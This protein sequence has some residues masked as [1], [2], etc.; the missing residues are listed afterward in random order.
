MEQS[1]AGSARSQGRPAGA[2]G[3]RAAVLLAVAALAAGGL[4]AAAEAATFTVNSTLDAVDRNPGDGLC[5]TNANTCTL[6]AAIQEANART[7]A[8]AIVVPTGVYAITRGGTSATTG[9]FDVTAPLTITGAGAGLTILDGGTP[10][11]GSIPERRGLD[12]LLDLSARAGNVTVSGLTLREG[13]DATQGGALA[14]LSPGTV[15]LVDVAIL[16]S[17]AVA[18]G[19]GVYHGGGGRLELAGVVLAGNASG[20]E[21]GGLYTWSGAVVVGPGSAP[22]VLTGNAARN[23]GGIFSAGVVGSDGRRA[24][25]DVVGATLFGNTA[26]L[27]GGGIL[28]G[29]EGDLMLTGT[30]FAE[31]AAGGAGGGVESTS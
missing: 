8:D 19:G 3:P 6:R 7:S 22:S 30:T 11:S 2:R 29:L 26:A 15:R 27:D 12:R 16:D 9:D 5:R 21:G 4:A 1:R 14:N 10:P 20:G 25:V 23:G 18:F 31:N 13:F 28:N 17:Y 24:S